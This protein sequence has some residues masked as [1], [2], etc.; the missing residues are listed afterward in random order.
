MVA[1]FCLLWSSA[2]AVAKLAVA[3]LPTFCS[4]L[5]ARFLLAG[6]F[7]LGARRN[8]RHEAAAPPRRGFPSSLRRSSGSAN[9]AAYL[10]LSYVG[11]PQHLC[12]PGSP[13]ESVCNPVLTARA[14]PRCSSAKRM[15][16]R[17]MVGLLLGVGRRCLR[18]WRA[19]LC[20]GRRAFRRHLFYA[21]RAGSRWQSATSCSR[22]SRPS[23]GPLDRHRPYKACRRVVLF[24][25]CCRSPSTFEK[26]RRPSYR[27]W[28]LLASIAYLALLVSVFAYLLW[29]QSPQPCRAR[30]R[31]V[32]PITS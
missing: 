11:N 20:V 18:W 2:F 27:G 8:L 21:R 23:G 3:E 19:R 13:R 28:R 30:P 17:K 26:R 32:V 1:A 5:T 12:W 25:R 7:M 15:T 9:Q 29:F 16:W 6:V 14:G 22:S 31:R 24:S 4:W 10:G